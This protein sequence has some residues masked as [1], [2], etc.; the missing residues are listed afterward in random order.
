MKP[1]SS[2]LCLISGVE[3]FTSY[4]EITYRPMLVCLSLH[5]FRTG[6]T[7][8]VGCRWFVP[9]GVDFFLSTMVTVT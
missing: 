3:N 6:V 7:S 8:G 4:S 1:I 2:K 9:N 5:S